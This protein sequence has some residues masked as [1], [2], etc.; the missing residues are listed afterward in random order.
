LWHPKTI[1]EVKNNSLFSLTWD[2]LKLKIGTGNF[3]STET[4]TEGKYLTKQHHS[5][6]TLGKTDGKLY[7]NWSEDGWTPQDI[8]LSDEDKPFVKILSVGPEVE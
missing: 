4:D 3:L 7:Y 8:K 1:E 6:A 5:L 2:G